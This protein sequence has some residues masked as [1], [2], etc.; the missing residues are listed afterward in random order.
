MLRFGL[1]VAL[2]AQ[3]LDEGAG[4]SSQQGPRRLDGGQSQWLCGVAMLLWVAAG[5][6]SG[7]KQPRGNGRMD[8]NGLECGHGA[9]VVVD[10]PV[11]SLCRQCCCFYSLAAL[12]EAM[13]K[14]EFVVVVH[15]LKLKP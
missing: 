5:T 10:V 1:H 6:V 7:L 3:Q 4:I 13:T 8:W 12:T 9:C 2:A 11:G 15:S 14:A